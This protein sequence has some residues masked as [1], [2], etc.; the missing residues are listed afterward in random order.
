MSASRPFSVILG[1]SDANRKL[2]FLQAR[3]DGS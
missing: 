3:A 2:P 1:L